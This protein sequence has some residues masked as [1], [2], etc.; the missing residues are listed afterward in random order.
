MD[1]D[2]GAD[3]DAVE[4]DG[5]V[6]RFTAPSFAT[7]A[8][9]TFSLTVTDALHMAIDT[10]DITVNGYR[11]TADAG[12]DQIV[13][14]GAQVVLDG[15]GSWSSTDLPLTFSWMQTAGPAV[16]LDNATSAVARFTAPNVVSETVLT[17]AVTVS[18]GSL[19]S[20]P[21]STSPCRRPK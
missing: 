16:T 3:G 14:A 9:L 19:M 13:D 12:E 2:R 11:L 10:I 1:S 6:A 20:S 8:V 15:S 5:A 17:F 7:D 21:R 4:S 18:D